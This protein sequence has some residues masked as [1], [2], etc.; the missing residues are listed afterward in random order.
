M[1]L[2]GTVP[3]PVVFTEGAPRER[4]VEHGHVARETIRK[5]VASYM[6]RFAYFSDLSQEAVRAAASSYVDP[7]RRVDGDLVTEM[8]GVAEGAGVHFLDL[9]A[10]NCRSELMFGRAALDCTSFA[11]TPGATADGHTYVAQN[12]D[13]APSVESSLILLVIRQDEGPTLVLLD[14]AG[15]IG[16]NGINSAGIGLG[17]N[18]LIAGSRATG[19]LPYN[20]VLRSALNQTSLADAIGA[21]VRVDRT[22]P[23]NYVLAS[24]EGMIVNIEASVDFV[25]SIDHKG[26]LITHGNHFEGARQRGRDSGLDRFPDSL[27]RS[28]HLRDSLEPSLGRLT[29]ADM[30]RALADR[31]GAPSAISRTGDERLAD[32][33]Q[34]AT[35]ASII[36]DVTEG[37]LWVAK[38]APHENEYWRFSVSELSVGDANP[39]PVGDHLPQFVSE[40]AAR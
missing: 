2:I 27:Y 25:E 9:L 20:M 26:G 37:C 3:M 30:R 38:G 18:T 40:K 1:P 24:R 22:M 23:A 5:G 16:R 14:E 6:S 7:I 13:W 31:R 10:V 35:V 11:V 39:T 12:W 28:C 15:M 32:H 29:P 19:G 21:I 33:D 4:G 34:L 17:S 8:E 36:S